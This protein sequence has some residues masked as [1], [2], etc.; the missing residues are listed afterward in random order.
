MKMKLNFSAFRI[1]LLVVLTAGVMTS[2]GK[3]DLLT[4]GDVK[5]A[6][7]EI[8]EPH[9]KYYAPAVIQTG[10]YE[11]NNENARTVL[12]KLA[13]AGVITYDAQ[14]VVEKV[15]HYYY[16]AEREH[17]FV[18]VALTPEG[19]KYVMSE[20]DAEKYQEAVENAQKG[21]DKDLES[22]NADTEYPESSIGAE[23]ITK[24]V[25]DDQPD[26]SGLTQEVVETPAQESEVTQPA[27]SADS[28]EGQQNKALTVYEKA[29]QQVSAETVYVE[30]HK[31]KLYKVR[32][33]LCTPA[34]FE[35]GQGEAEVILE[36]CDVTPFGRI[37]NDIRDG[38]KILNKWEFVY[39]NDS[40]W[41]IADKE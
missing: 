1:A 26:G 41:A 18:S 24:I 2:C 39:Y 31:V 7:K 38:N 6:V 27:E 35:R 11:L 22:P 29:L 30:S 28:D 32:H 12:R 40:G 20:E 19:E 37:L 16:S 25:R 21:S 15:Q 17:V 8:L 34:M 33:V 13:A 10:F 4:V 3:S 9:G 36:Y 14:I 23:V 5:N